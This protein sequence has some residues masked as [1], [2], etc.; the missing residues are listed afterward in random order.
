MRETP[1]DNVRSNERKAVKGPECERKPLAAESSRRHRTLSAACIPASGTHENRRI[2]SAHGRCA[3][4]R[5]RSSYRSPEGSSRWGRRIRGR[6]R[7]SRELQG[8]GG[9]GRRHRAT[10]ALLAHDP[11]QRGRVVPLTGITSAAEEAFRRRP[12]GAGGRRR[13]SG[14]LP[15]HPDLQRKEWHRKCRT[16]SGDFSRPP[17]Q[18]LSRCPPPVT[19]RTDGNERGPSS[20]PLRVVRS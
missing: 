17:P 12:S 9:R 19:V 1:N 14:L 7:R 15:A 16:G 6:S 20:R 13:I 8:R 4:S 5:G 3:G 18:P 11:A 10:V 2:P